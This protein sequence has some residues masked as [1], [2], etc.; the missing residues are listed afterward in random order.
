M[1]TKKR[2]DDPYF[3]SLG[4]YTATQAA[5]TIQQTGGDN[6]LT[7]RPLEIARVLPVVVDDATIGEID[8]ALLRVFGL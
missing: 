7:V 8:R 4:L 1:T 2:T 3:S 6:S 5:A